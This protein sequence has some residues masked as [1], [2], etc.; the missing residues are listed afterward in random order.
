MDTQLEL[1][2]FQSHLENTLATH[3]ESTK[4]RNC[5]TQ[6]YWHCAHTAESVNVRVQNYRIA[7]AIYTLQTQFVLGI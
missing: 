2:P 1:E 4:S 6:P 3:R 5:R 7:A